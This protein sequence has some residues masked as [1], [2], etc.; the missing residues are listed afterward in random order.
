M[1]WYG[2][3]P[4]EDAHH[5]CNEIAKL[6]IDQLPANHRHR[7]KMAYMEL[8]ANALQASARYGGT[9]IEMTWTLE[10]HQ[11]SLRLTNEGVEFTPTAEQFIM[12]HAHAENGRGLPMILLMANA[13]HY[14][15]DSGNTVAAVH[16]TIPEYRT[17]TS[18]RRFRSGWS[19][20]G[21]AA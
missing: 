2:L 4:I 16:W 18:R 14:Y 15:H 12:P 11:L 5:R 6:V 10:G 13:L 19:F 7:V 21:D 20:G 3:Y 1:E 8:L 9:E 17:R